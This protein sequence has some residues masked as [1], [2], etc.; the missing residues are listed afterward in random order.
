MRAIILSVLTL[1]LLNLTTAAICPS[2]LVLNISNSTCGNSNG[3]L[4]INSVVDGDAPFVYSLNGSAFSSTVNYSGLTSGTYYVTVQDVNNCTFTDTVIITNTAGPII[5]NITY[6]QPVCNG[7]YNGTATVIPSGGSPPYSYQ[8]A[9]APPQ[10]TQTATSLSAGVYQVNVRDQNNCLVSGTVIITEP[11]PLNILASPNDTICF[12]GMSMVYAAALGGTPPYSYSW[13]SIDSTTGGPFVV[14]PNITTLYTVS[15]VDQHGCVSNSQSIVLYVNSP[16]NSFT[17]VPDS[18]NSLNYLAF[19]STSGNNLSYSWNFGDGSGSTLQSPTHLYSNPGTYT[20]TLISNSSTCSDTTSQTINVVSTPPSCLSLF[21]I[22]D[23]V[24][25]FSPYAYTIYNFS[26]GGSLSY[27]WDFGDGSTSTLANPS[28]L[29]AGSG[30]YEICL[31]INNGSGCV[32]THCDT[33]I[34]IDSIDRSVN[35][36]SINVVRYTSSVTGIEKNNSHE[37]N[38]VVSPN[39]FS[40]TATF[41]IQSKEPDD[42]YSFELI[43]L[44]GKTVRSINNISEGK[45]SIHKNDLLNGVYFY[46]IYNVNEQ[47]NTGKLIIQ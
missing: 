22:G 35:Q 43:D 23:D 14:S 13:I 28:H 17:M 10:Y 24:S 31:T 40:E 36:L 7:M 26:Y 15:A 32:Q 41:T 3:S 19:N 6:T 2:A 11:S 37:H 44:L 33:L 45:F 25:S 29:Y 46:K 16:L 18:S 42:I 8:W 9:T 21:N 5:S 47:I 34:S 27:L 12:D 30:P 20:V 38:I 1:L 4:Q 39:P